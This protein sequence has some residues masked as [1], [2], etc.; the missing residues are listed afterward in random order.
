MLSAK[1]RSR[2][3]HLSK[4]LPQLHASS[5]D[6]ASLRTARRVYLT[7]LQVMTVMLK[8][9]G[10]LSVCARP[11][12]ALRYDATPVTSD[13]ALVD[14]DAADDDEACLR[15]RAQGALAS[16]ELLQQVRYVF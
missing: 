6:L 10:V 13:T 2:C 16:V 9:N 8:Y 11:Q 3:A 1:V 12:R 4:H 14:G 15:D 7:Q 5:N